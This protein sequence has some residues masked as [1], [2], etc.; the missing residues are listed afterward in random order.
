VRVVVQWKGGTTTEL[1]V[2]MYLHGSAALCHRVCDMTCTH[3]DSEIAALLNQEGH[4]TYIGKAWTTE[5]LAGFRTDHA[6]PSAFT[7]VEALRLRESGYVTTAEAAAQ[8][9]VQPQEVLTWVR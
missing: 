2:P 3:T 9:D 6:I 7:T 5:R 4:T 1:A 8:V